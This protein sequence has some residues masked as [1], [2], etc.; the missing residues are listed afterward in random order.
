MNLPVEP[1]RLVEGVIALTLLEAAA[2]A[3]W[4]HWR[5]TGP[6]LRDWALHLAS[7]LCLMLAL[8]A[9]LVD[10]AAPV[11]MAWLA[12]AGAVHALDLRLRWIRS[13]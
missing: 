12:L 2:I 1:A 6:A 3:A 13:T 8:R 5:G 10:S 4:R 11:W 7:G 9:A